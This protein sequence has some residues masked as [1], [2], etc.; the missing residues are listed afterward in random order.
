MVYL[1]STNDIC[2]KFRIKRVNCNSFLY[3]TPAVNGG[4]L[5]RIKWKKTFHIR[6]DASQIRDFIYQKLNNHA[7]FVISGWCYVQVAGLKWYRPRWTP[8]TCN[9]ELYATTQYVKSE[10]TYLAQ[11]FTGTRMDTSLLD[12]TEQCVGR[13]V[14]S[15]ESPYRCVC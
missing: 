15:L 14:I 3:E 5:V 12:R 2:I 7:R 1:Y 9:T 8:S 6:R 13:S 4:L 11:L 10:F